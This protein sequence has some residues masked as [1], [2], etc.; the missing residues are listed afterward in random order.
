[1]GVRLSGWWRARAAEEEF[2]A[3]LEAHVEMHTE[4]GVRAGLTRTEARRQALLRLGGAEQTRQAHRERRTVAWLDA[5]GQDVRYGLRTLRRSPGFAVTAVM[6]LALGIGACTAIFSLVNAVLIRSLPYG[7]P[8]QLVYFFAPNPH[9][10]I[11]PEVICPNYGDFFDIRAQNKSF[12]DMT[13]FEQAMFNVTLQGTVD[14]VGAARVDERFFRTLGSAPERGRAI[15]GEDIMAGRDKVV[16]ISHSLW[17]AMFA[18]SGDVLGRTVQLD[19]SAYRVIGVMGKG[20]EYPFNFDLPYGNSSVKSTQI[21]I[22]LV[23]TARQRADREM[24]NDEVIARLRT[25]VSMSAA[26]AEM[27]TRMA[28]LDKLHGTEAREQG[29]YV[30]GFL[31]NAVGPVRQLMWLLLGAVGMVLLIACGNAANL[32]LA[33]AANRTREL[34]VRVALGAGKGRIVRQL[35][36]E[37]LLIGVAAGV[38]GVGLAWVF[39]RMLPW[40][41]PGNIPR[42]REATLDMRVMAFTV[43]VSL[44]TSVLAGMLPALAILRADLAGFLATARSRGGVHT[45]L[46]SVLIVAEAALVVVLLTGA[47]LLVRSYINVASVETGFAPSTLSMNVALDSR[48]AKPEQS[49][50]FFRGFLERVRA[51]PGVQEAGAIN[52]L[53]L[54]NSESLSNFYVDGFANTP[55]QLLE[56][57]SVTPSY[58]AAM[59][60]PLKAGR[61]LTG[62]DTTAREQVA[63]V[64]Q[65]FADTYLAHRNPIGAR[66]STDEHHAQWTTVVGVVGDVRHSSLEEGPV[67]QMYHANF[68]FDSAYVTV[69]SGL[70]GDV[71]MAAIRAVLKGMDGNLAL[72]DVRT[73]RELVSE[74]S[75]RRRFQTSLLTVF[76]GIALF[77]A[78]VGLY[79]LMAYS[80]SLRTQE[81]GVRMALGAQR[82]DVMLLVL[83][84]AAWLLS[85]GLA[86]GLAGAWVAARAMK[87][88]LFGV[89]AHDPATL[90]GVCGL[91]AVCGCVAALVPARRA[92]SIDPMV[93]LRME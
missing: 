37:S 14:R 7:D 66:I 80:V 6:T 62:R 59:N 17:Q 43:A 63:L 5:L 74:A 70:P 8:Q 16:V 67:A 21:W 61:M 15:G 26:Q 30:K 71:T 50:A 85:A 42:L 44:G 41:D 13:A 88:F 38:A 84:R 23:L 78:V 34:G 12:A 77:L 72:T 40:L 28:Q 54:S 51:L 55:E 82:W 11:P 65:K 19:G 83:G 31:D 48:Y 93:A 1:L 57:R 47:G 32:L 92:A 76:A 79:S 60:I 39:L 18:G 69:R 75:A 24:G 49:I 58:F 68:E 27:T 45:R 3:E 33:R 4:D 46:Q 2:G 91:L 87:A 81:M 29:A 36:T 89:G 22:P 9:I 73:M 86:V 20:F 64:N 90:M 10:P 53:P 52:S 35:M 56:A 25:G